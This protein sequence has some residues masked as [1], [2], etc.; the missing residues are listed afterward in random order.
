MQ[1]ERVIILTR[2]EKIWFN[3]IQE[4]RDYPKLVTL[5]NYRN[6][7]ITPGNCKNQGFELI[8]NALS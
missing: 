2:G 5:K 6:I 8:E 1:E 3:A 7:C 4:L